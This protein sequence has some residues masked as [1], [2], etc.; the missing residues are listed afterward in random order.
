MSQRPR[1]RQVAPQQIKAIV[2]GGRGYDARRKQFFYTSL[3]GERFDGAAAK[4][5]MKED[6]AI[7]A[8]GQDFDSMR[9][10]LACS[11]STPTS[12]HD[13][14]R[15]VPPPVVDAYKAKG[16]AQLFDWQVACLQQVYG[17]DRESQGTVPSPENQHRAPRNLV[18][19]APT[20]GGKTL[21]AEILLLKALIRRG[22]AALF[23]QPYIALV[24]EKARHF[25]QV[26]KELQIS[27]QTL[28]GES[29]S[30]LDDDHADIQVRL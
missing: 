24:E 9:G 17:T 4:A 16:I 13:L 21:V 15:W 14:S 29:G 3:T 10:S 30:F 27:V 11:S 23:V 2:N 19:S 6:E 18:Y 26:W 1:S 7:L 20:S 5:R 28:H 8:R 25:R 12:L 22:G